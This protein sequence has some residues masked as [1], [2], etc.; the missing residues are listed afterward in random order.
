MRN[1]GVYVVLIVNLYLLQC[2][3]GFAASSIQRNR[4]I[5]AVHSIKPLF[6][7][8]W[9]LVRK[10]MLGE[11]QVDEVRQ[12]LH[13]EGKKRHINDLQVYSHLGFVIASYLA[14]INKVNDLHILLNIVTIFSCG[15]HYQY[16][17]PGKLA[18]A[19]SIFAKLLFIYGLLQIS[20]TTTNTLKIAEIILAISTVAI[21]ITTN[22]I[23]S[24][25][26]P[27]HALMHII[28]SIWASIVAIYHTPLLLI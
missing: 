21:L 18:I 10:L 26:E 6:Q 19:D 7:S 4:N 2:V 3:T 27:W 13:L 28:P 25:Y 9:V 14:R 8:G 15:Y 20:N 1:L 5:I 12:K 17:K 23:R 16:E 24:L 22:T 11:G